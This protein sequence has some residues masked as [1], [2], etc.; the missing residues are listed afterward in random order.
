MLQSCD[1]L[2][3]LGNATQ[4]GQTIFAKNSDRPSRECQPLVLREQ[5]R[6]PAGMTVQC[7]FVELP[8]VE[9]TYR[10][11]GS[12]P[13]WC[14]GYEHGFNEHQ[15]VI[16][17]EALPTKLSPFTEA[18]LIG[19][20]ILRLGLERSRSAAEAVT[21]MTNLIARHGQGKFANEAGVRTYDNGFIIAD[22]K[23]A[24][25]LETAGHEWV[26][27]AVE[28]TTGISNVHSVETDW[29]AISPRAERFAR[30]QGWWSNG[31]DQKS[32]NFAEAYSEIDRTR[33]SG[34][35]RRKRSRALLNHHAGNIDVQTMINI[36][37]DHGSGD[38]DP[39]SYEAE[40]NPGTGIC[41]HGKFEG[42]DGNTAASLVADLCADGSRLPV[43]WC[44]FYSPC[45]GLFFPVFLEGSLPSTL[46]IGEGVQS[47][48]SPWW[49]FYQLSQLARTDP[50][51]GVSFVR[52]GWTDF[53][54]DLFDSAYRVAVEG[55]QLINCNR[56]ED[57]FQLLSHYMAESV[58]EM[59]QKVAQLSAQL[60]Q[61]L[62]PLLA[63]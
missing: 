20:E 45:L 16:G 23:E 25:V 52:E 49:R 4:N 62:T 5:Q 61:E 3:A 59:M 9:V 8:Q 58:D 13:H 51:M 29:T 44:S 40:I 1:T 34:P 39:A 11:V 18:K 60:E 50:E 15:V 56:K 46:S 24:Y 27:K 36:L 55:Q 31:P 19:M 12:R 63:K 10:H 7:Q 54:M 6:H 2:V 43:Y 26:V 22:P 41:V 21:V 14:W 33:G 57:A 37:S 32:F 17:N 47:D 38:A 42:G 35:T 30:E 53:Q 28:M 48:G